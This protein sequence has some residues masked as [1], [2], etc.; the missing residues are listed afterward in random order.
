[1]K[2]SSCGAENKASV[3]PCEYCGAPLGAAPKAPVGSSSATNSSSPDVVAMVKDLPN[4]YQQLFQL[5]N[6]NFN[7]WAFLFPVGFMAGYG[8]SNAA[9]RSGLMILAPSVIAAILGA[10]SWRLLFAVHLIAGIFI[11]VLHIMF[12]LKVAA[13]SSKTQPFNIGSAVL[14]ELILL[15]IGGAVSYL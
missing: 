13:I 7:F 6:Q 9:I 10:L 5:P 8:D 4:S 11:F 2:C 3:G 1:M 15:L 14:F 12:G